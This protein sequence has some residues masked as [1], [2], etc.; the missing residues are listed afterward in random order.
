MKLAGELSSVILSEMGLGRR[1]HLFF[2][3]PSTLAFVVG[4]ALGKHNPIAVYH[5]D[6]KREVYVRIFQLN[7]LS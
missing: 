5:H 6:R 1:V 4:T 3:L 7:E 2:G